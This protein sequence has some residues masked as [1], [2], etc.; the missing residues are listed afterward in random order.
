MLRIRVGPL[1]FPG[2]PHTSLNCLVSECPCLWMTLGTN[3]HP[4]TSSLGK[5]SCYLLT[6]R[7]SASLGKCIGPGLPNVNEGHNQELLTFALGLCH[8]ASLGR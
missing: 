1:P 4:A 7:I 5:A 3:L 2:V 6:T 8:L